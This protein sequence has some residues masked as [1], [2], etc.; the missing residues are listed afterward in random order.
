MTDEEWASPEWQSLVDLGRRFVDAH[1]FSGIRRATGVSS[2]DS[3]G[4]RLLRLMRWMHGHELVGFS[5]L[6]PEKAKSF[7]ADVAGCDLLAAVERSDDTGLSHATLANYAEIL[8]A[9]YD[10]RSE[11]RAIPRAEIAH[12]PFDG[13]P[14]NKVAMRHIEYVERHLPAMPTEVFNAII[15]VAQ[16]W[17]RQYSSDILALQREF[18][19]ARN[20]A[21]H[22]KGNSY[23]HHTDRALM[24]FR[25]DL[26]GST[27]KPW[28]APIKSARD[29]KADIPQP[30]S[31]GS[32]GPS[33]QFKKLL[34]ELR[35]TATILVQASTGMRISEVLGL[36]I[37]LRHKDGWP[38][39]LTSRPSP[40]GLYELFFIKGVI[41]KTEDNEPTEAEWLAGAR[42]IGTEWLPDAVEAVLLLDRLF[43]PWRE[44]WDSERLIV[45]FGKGRGP[46]RTITPTESLE[47]GQVRS[48]SI[49][50]GQRGFVAEHV[51]LPDSCHDWVISTHQ[52]RSRWARDIVE[53]DPK[54]TIS[55]Q[56]QL[57]HRYLATSE[58]AYIGN[59]PML[60]RMVDDRASRHTATAMHDFVYGGL[61]AGG[62][63]AEALRESAP[64]IKAFCKTY[65][66]KDQQ[67][68]ALR[69]LLDAD[70]I[71]LWAGPSGDCLFHS[72]RARC[73][74]REFGEFVSTATRPLT[75]HRTTDLCWSCA[76]FIIFA[77][78]RQYWQNRY[79]ENI[80]I[81]EHNQAHGNAA[82]R[83]LAELRASQAKQA[84]DWIKEQ[85]EGQSLAA[86]KSSPFERD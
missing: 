76:N 62:R 10:H 51:T 50:D 85:Q 68:D 12:H 8:V 16:K 58:A 32:A 44:V 25:F 30:G 24:A 78:H 20:A 27:P 9:I 59:D 29:A 14:A 6:T 42:P 46:P 33:S 22:Y 81:A 13:D 65:G 31:K 84:L 1:R 48:G 83:L 70:G 63:M 53:I 2:L 57:H 61:T 60:N 35:D 67:V 11:L 75:T 54:L 80:T 4:T 5:D 73:H 74:H 40:S 69:R 66:T 41:F 37:G 28:R 52:F 39:C 79:A 15:P 55:V 18:L 38:A 43:A 47:P 71:R 36:V 21:S 19:R 64:S 26:S 3:I 82:G 77:R 49:R 45:S 7:V 34:S 17:V 72:D 56:E 86:R 23:M